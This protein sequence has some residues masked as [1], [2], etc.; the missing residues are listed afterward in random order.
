MPGGA[1]LNRSQERAIAALLTSP[2]VAEAARAAGVSQRSLFGWMKRPEFN[3]QYREARRQVI[4]H[5]VTLLQQ[6]TTKAAE[7]LNRSMS[8]GHHAT[9]LRAAIAVMELSLKG[10]GRE[11]TDADAEAE[12]ADAAD[13]SSMGADAVVR[14]LAARLRQVDQS[15]LPTGEKARLS[16]SLADSLLRALA[17][18]VLDQRLAAVQA[19]LSGRKDKP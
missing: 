2:S 10:I 17:V 3:R 16:A 1:K 6:A 14:L 18:G 13:G 11:L 4:E 12:E 8:C 9:E 5:A 15:A 7:T 19:V